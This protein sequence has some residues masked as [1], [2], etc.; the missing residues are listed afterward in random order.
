MIMSFDFKSK[1]LAGRNKEGNLILADAIT[2]EDLP[3]AAGVVVASTTLAIAAVG[4]VIY[5]VRRRCRT[6][7]IDQ[8][9]DEQVG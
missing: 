2:G 5:L 3:L 9:A 8:P 4:G 6:R 7:N 1:V